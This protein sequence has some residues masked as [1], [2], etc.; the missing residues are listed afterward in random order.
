M[1]DNNSRNNRSN[2]KSEGENTKI[3]KVNKKKKKKPVATKSGQGKNVSATKK[4]QTPNGKN[5][6]KGAKKGKHPKLMMAFK[7]GIILFL[8]LCVI[9]AGIVAGMFFGLFGDEF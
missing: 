9:G 5:S 6:K 8:L 2:K 7:I 3:Y 4:V 1:P